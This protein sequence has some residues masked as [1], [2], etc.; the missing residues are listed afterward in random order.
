MARIAEHAPA[1]DWLIAAVC[2]YTHTGVELDTLTQL[3]A[4]HPRLRLAGLAT[5][6]LYGTSPMLILGHLPDDDAPQSARPTAST[7]AAPAERVRASLDFPHRQVVVEDWV[8][9]AELGTAP[10]GAG[11]LLRVHTRSSDRPGTLSAMVDELA[12][13]LTKVARARPGQSVPVWFLHTDVADGRLATSRLLVRLPKELAAAAADRA[14]LDRVERV[15]QQALM[16]RLDPGAPLSERGEWIQARAVVSIDVVTAAQGARPVLPGPVETAG[17]Q[18]R[19]VL[20]V[21]AAESAP[22]DAEL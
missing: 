1:G 21:D 7:A 8:Q 17:S 2:G 6:V 10:V 19:T 5:A 4:Q 13:G 12:R 3:G 18:V 11:L 20:D 9:T 22:S 16:T 14:T 15:V